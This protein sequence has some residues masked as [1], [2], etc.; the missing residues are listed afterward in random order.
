[1]NIR[2]ITLG[3]KVNQCESASIVATLRL[4]NYLASEGL[5]P[6]D[7]YILNTCSVTAEADKK[8]RQ[9][10]AKMR[11]LNPD[12]KIIVVGCSSQNH[13][14]AFAKN[15]VI[16]IGGTVNKADFI[17]NTVKNIYKNNQYN[18]LSNIILL[19][20]LTESVEKCRTFCYE[21]Y[22]ISNKT[23]AFIKIQDGCNRFCT[24]CIIPYLRGRSR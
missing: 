18:T 7:V 21:E 2:V 6:A 9:Y 24:Y 20:N 23:R 1:M 17:L 14:H 19:D 10:V 22:P 3:C 8:S 15:N 12:C 13:P 4:N 16:A 11:K 5:E